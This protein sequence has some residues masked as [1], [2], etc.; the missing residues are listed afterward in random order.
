MS[1]G[2]CGQ[3]QAWTYVESLVPYHLLF[4]E[5]PHLGEVNAWGRGPTAREEI[6]GLNL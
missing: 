1:E 3:R 5:C 6:Q 2:Q 4:A